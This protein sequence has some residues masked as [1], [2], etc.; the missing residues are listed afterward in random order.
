MIILMALLIYM[1]LSFVVILLVAL[2]SGNAEENIDSIDMDYMHIVSGRSTIVKCP[3]FIGYSYLY[4]HRGWTARIP[5]A[6]WIWGK[7]NR[8]DQMHCHFEKSFYRYSH[9]DNAVLD[10][11]ADDYFKAYFNDDYA[12]CSCSSKC[13]LH[14]HR[15]RCYVKSFIRQG[16]NKLQIYV[17][18]RGGPAGLLYR[19]H[20]FY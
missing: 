15:R 14:S 19:L 11:A 7:Y 20:L 10:V 4:Y 18:N 12:Y 13:W 17:W 1:K 5:G 6:R 8:G 9:L 2:H 16:N 3:G